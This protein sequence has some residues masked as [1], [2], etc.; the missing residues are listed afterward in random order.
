MILEHQTKASNL[1]TWAGWEAR[2]GDPERTKAAAEALADYLLFVGEAP[3]PEPIAGSPAFAASFTQRGPRDAAGRSLRDL[4]LERRLMK[5]P[6]SYM[7]YTPTF[8]AL[9]D[10]ARSL[11]RAR[12]QAVLTGRDQ[13]PKYAHL[14]AEDRRAILEI[15]RETKPDI[16]AA[17]P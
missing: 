13:A 11:V 10:G 8:D 2:L 9:P 14:S 17:V 15:L 3:I 6:L 12:L 4:D 1:M 5:Y 7:V 16:A